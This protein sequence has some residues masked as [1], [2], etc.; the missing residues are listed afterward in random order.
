MTLDKN[1]GSVGADEETITD[2]DYSNRP[3]WSIEARTVNV[4]NDYATVEA[5]I[6]DNLA[7]F[8]SHSLTVQVDTATNEDVYVPPTI[9]R[10]IPID[11]GSESITVV[12]SGSGSINSFFADG[13]S[14]MEVRLANLDVTGTNPF[15][16]EGAAIAFY[17]CAGRCSVNSA[18]VSGGSVSNGLISYS[19]DVTVNG[20]ALTGTVG[21]GLTTKHMGKLNVVGDVTGSTTTNVFR[22]DGGG[23]IIVHPD[24]RPVS[25]TAG[26]VYVESNSHG[27]FN[28]TVNVGSSG[29][30]ASFQNNVAIDSNNEVEWWR[31]GL[32]N[33]VQGDGDGTLV[34]ITAAPR[35]TIL[36]LEASGAGDITV[37]HASGNRT[38]GNPILLQTGSNFTMPAAQSKLVLAIGQGDEWLEIGRFG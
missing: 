12:V 38:N 6:A 32:Q 27:I 1:F 10:R 7:V 4:P 15:D 20:L 8:Q 18:T 28:G 3:L 33:L 21:V 36:V 5:A 11:A 25:A 26:D 24:F 30:S 34:G 13:I 17:G 16:N 35:G 9:C 2:T 14:G 19:S 23:S 31:G 22:A 29:M 37:V